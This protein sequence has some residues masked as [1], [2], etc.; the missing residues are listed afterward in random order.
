MW[1]IAKHEFL[2]NVISLRFFIGS[3]LCLVLMVSSM[4]VLTDDY[5]M[6][7]EAYDNSVGEHLKEAKQTMVFSRLQIMIDRPALS[8][9]ILEEIGYPDVRK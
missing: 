3:V 8:T 9:D 6:R 5:A 2:S 4:Y 7:L 1:T